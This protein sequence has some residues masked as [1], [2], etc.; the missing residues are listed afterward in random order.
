MFLA[1][2]NR[3]LKEIAFLQSHVVR[4][5]LANIIGL[6]NLFNENEMS[7]EQKNYLKHLK[8][9]GLKLDELIKGLA[10][11]IREIEKKSKEMLY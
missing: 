6:L 2:Q 11:R 7:D 4:P 3:E 9:T 10:A 5:P 1:E 8:D